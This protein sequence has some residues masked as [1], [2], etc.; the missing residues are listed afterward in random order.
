MSAFGV[1]LIYPRVDSRVYKFD[2][3]VE[4]FAVDLVAGSRNLGS[5]NH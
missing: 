3:Y 1:S 2:F 4:A 5:P